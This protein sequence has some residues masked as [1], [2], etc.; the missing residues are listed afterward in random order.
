MK[1][2]ILNFVIGLACAPFMIGI[3][4]RT[5]AKFAGRKGEPLLQTYFDM[6]KLL[7]KGTVYSKTTTWI[8]RI[9]PSIG[10]SSVII[11]LAIIPLHGNQ[12]L[13]HFPG[14]L[15]LLIYILGLM[16]FFTVLAALDTGSSFEGM[17]G[18]REVLFSFLAE[19]ALI[20]G[21]C[22]FTK[23]TGFISL[24]DS[25]P[26]T[27]IFQPEIILVVFALF[28]V[29]LCEN[30]R[31]PI[32]DPNTHLELTMIHE[33]M[34]LDYSGPDFAFVTY[35]SSIKMW[36]LGMIIIESILPLNSSSAWWYNTSLSLT[37]MAM[38]SVT[39]GIVE[40]IMARLRLI[41]VP[42]LLIAADSLSI[43]AFI[44]VGI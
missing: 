44:L 31:I 1:Y 35:S 28:I 21:L 8:F 30:A 14:D 10:L 24:S 41:S 18:S 3:I 5:K 40:S 38:L 27:V 37:G 26:N 17:G 33:V 12:S 20:A 29:F 23:T 25:L 39:V 9:A 11:A 42:K 43:L 16:V 15:F 13:I 6:F 22:V 34:V 4:N 7:R 19:P 36:V 2:S 32:D